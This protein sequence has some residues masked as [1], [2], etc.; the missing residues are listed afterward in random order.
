MD[1]EATNKWLEGCT[2]Q[3]AIETSTKSLDRRTSTDNERARI[4]FSKTSFQEESRSTDSTTSLFHY[5]GKVLMASLTHVT[6]TLQQY[7]DGTPRGFS[8]GMQVWDLDDL[9]ES[10]TSQPQANRN[11]LSTNT[12]YSH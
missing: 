1:A 11:R 6:T 3:S 7:A 5:Q 8:A 9:G 2:S 10:T 12:T 4:L